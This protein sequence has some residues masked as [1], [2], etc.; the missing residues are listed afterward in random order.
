MNDDARPLN[1]LGAVGL[2]AL[3]NPL[4]GY[5]LFTLR[6]LRD[7]GPFFSVLGVEEVEFLRLASRFI[8]E[9]K[10]RRPLARSVVAR[11]LAKQIIIH[12]IEKPTVRAY[13]CLCCRHDLCI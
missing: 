9:A 12:M 6:L 1:V 4:S 5:G 10:G 11:S 13:R 2:V 3:T 8:H 7:S